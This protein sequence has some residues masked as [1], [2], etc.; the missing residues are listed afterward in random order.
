MTAE[1][2]RHADFSTLRYA[3]VWEDTEVLLEALAIQP[4]DTCLAIASAGDHAL[5]MLTREPAQVVAVDV[6]PA[7]LA[8]LRLR[9]AAYRVLDHPALLELVGSRPSARRQAL[10]AKCRAALDKPTRAFWDARP[11]LIAGGLGAA[12]KFERYF[13]H[14]R[15]WVLPWVHRRRTVRALFEPREPAERRRF[16]ER[17]WN[18][19]RWRAMFALFFSRPVMSR[20][21]RDPAFF[22]YVEGPVAGRLFQRAEHALAELDP[23]ANPYLHWILTGTHGAAL[24]LALRPE[25]FEPI[26]RN[27]DRV[28]IVHSSL[29]TA[30]GAMP[31]RFVDRFNLSDVFEYMS[32]AN[33]EALLRQCVAR[34]RPGGRL[35]YWNMLVP[36]RRPEPMADVLC[37]LEAQAEALHRVDQ[38]FFYSRLVIEAIT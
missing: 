31:E 15:R 12:G 1:A 10:Y 22:R 14:F 4:G 6:N 16:Y 33:A 29:E 5:A 28:R 18:N 13:A 34:G 38:A 35:V 27:L 36:R 11:A 19:R 9:I 25:S 7:Q 20:L 26:R 24:P 8:C 2:P 3:Q 21:G 37:P 30:L 23:A 32:A 17:T